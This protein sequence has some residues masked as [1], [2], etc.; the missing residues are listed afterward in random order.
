MK[1][2]LQ[3]RG[4]LVPQRQSHTSGEQVQDLGFQSSQ[5]KL[6]GILSGNSKEGAIPWAAMV[7][8]EGEA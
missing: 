3:W 4:V 1:P 8:S 5:G 2:L 7:K 6:M